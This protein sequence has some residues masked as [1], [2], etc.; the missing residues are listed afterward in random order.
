MIGRSL[1]RKGLLCRWGFCSYRCEKFLFTERVKLLPASCAPSSYLHFHLDL[2]QTLKTVS[3]FPAALTNYKASPAG[4]RTNASQASFPRVDLK[5]SSLFPLWT[6]FLDTFCDIQMA[7]LINSYGLVWGGVPAVGC[8]SSPVSSFLICPKHIH[9][10]TLGKDRTNC[11]KSVTPE[12]EMPFFEPNY[13]QT[14][15]KQKPFWA[16]GNK[17]FGNERGEIV[18]KAGRGGEEGK[19]V[20]HTRE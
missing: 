19:S 3:L 4:A 6:F 5:N 7:S 20:Y 11:S 12:S 2:Q 13:P 14:P 15:Q 1:L 18:K 9:C 17:W 16:F 10:A 8:V